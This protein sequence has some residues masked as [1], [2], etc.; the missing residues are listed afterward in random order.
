MSRF[1]VSAAPELIHAARLDA[2]LTQAQ[3]AERASLSEDDL[4]AMESGTHSTSDK[5]L[6]NILRAADYRPSIP[7]SQHADAIIASAHAHGLSRPRVF[8]SVAR[9]EDGFDSGGLFKSLE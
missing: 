9:G 1:A 8:G 2:G 3:L 6:E 5:A 4:V 7:L